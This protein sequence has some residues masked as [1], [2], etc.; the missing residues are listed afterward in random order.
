MAIVMEV[1]CDKSEEEMDLFT[2]WG[3]SLRVGAKHFWHVVAVWE[4]F[5]NW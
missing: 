5:R 4:S 3:L 2:L 1:V